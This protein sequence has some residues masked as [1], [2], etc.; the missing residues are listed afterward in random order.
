M[1]CHVHPVTNPTHLSLSKMSG[2]RYRKFQ[3]L[4]EQ[5]NA[6]HRAGANLVGN[7]VGNI[8]QG[9]AEAVGSLTPP[10]VWDW[11]RQ[12]EQD[13][14]DFGS[15]VGLAGAALTQAIEYVPQRSGVRGK[16]KRGS[17]DALVPKF[18]ILQS[19]VTG[20]GDSPP[21]RNWSSI[22]GSGNTEVLPSAPK[23]T[24]S[25]EWLRLSSSRSST[26]SFF[27]SRSSSLSTN[28]LLNRVGWTPQRRLK[29]LLT[30]RKFFLPR[31]RRFRLRKAKGLVRRRAA[32]LL[33]ARRA[34]PPVRVPGRLGLKD[35]ARWKKRNFRQ[36]LAAKRS[37]AFAARKYRILH[38]K[39][40]RRRRY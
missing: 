11:A 6:V 10:V 36:H 29:H 32:K 12:H 21:S 18:N 19:P 26:G 27:G 9:T 28:T 15:A 16:R 20:T 30:L 7:H 25:Q 3:R 37:L 23:S 5:V 14:R 35:I 13:I 1:A 34:R 4:V 17:D 2:E 24:P 22:G 33:F 39:Y 38:R 40:K 31:I 8:I